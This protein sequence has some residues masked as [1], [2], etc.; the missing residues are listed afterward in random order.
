MP[1]AKIN[2]LS[3]PLNVKAKLVEN[4]LD[5]KS[6]DQKPTRDGYGLGLLQA[7]DE[8]LNVVALCAEL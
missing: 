4:V 7:A 8:N 1:L 3:M 2:Y 6:L 5:V